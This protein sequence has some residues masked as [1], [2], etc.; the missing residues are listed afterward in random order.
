MHP[1]SVGTYHSG[2]GRLVTDR[3]P[4]S[5]WQQRGNHAATLGYQDIEGSAGGWRIHHVQP[6][7]GSGQ[8]GA[9]A[10]MWKA[11]PSAGAKQ[12]DLRR[13]REQFSDALGVDLLEPG[14]GPVQDGALREQQQGALLL[15]SID[16]DKTRSVAGDRIERRGRISV[17]FQRGTE[18]GVEHEA[19]R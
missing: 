11:L 16:F 10:R 19:T 18:S 12:H 4:H 13:M 8:C 14:D 17:K 9:D 7:P 5:D 1:A 3:K 6:D 15:R 2:R